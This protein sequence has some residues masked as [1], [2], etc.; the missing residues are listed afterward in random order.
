MEVGLI[1]RALWRHKTG[2]LLIALQMALTLAVLVNAAIMLQDHRRLMQRP[3]GLD[4]ANT[5]YLNSAVFQT[6]AASKAAV[7]RDL[8][9]LRQ[10]PGVQ[11]ATQINAIP[12]SGNGAWWSVATAAGAGQPEVSVAYYQVDEHGLAALGVQLIAGDNFS[13]SD[14]MWQSAEHNPQ[15]A[16]VIISAALARR[17]FGDEQSGVLGK[18]IYL[19]KTQPL[20]VIGVVAKLQA[21]WPDWKNAE[22]SL[23]V[24]VQQQAASHWYLVR[25][26]P[27]RRDALMPQLESR[28]AQ[29]DRQRIVSEMTTLPQTRQRAYQK[30]LAASQVL[31]WLIIALTG[32]T[33][34]GIAGLVMFSLQRRH[35]MIGIRRALGATRS[36]IMRFFM[37]E[38]LLISGLGALLG[39]AV[40]IGLNIWLVSRLQVSPLGP[41]LLLAGVVAMLLLGQLAVSYPA[42]LAT[43]LSPASICRGGVPGAAT[44]PISAL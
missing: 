13:A 42:W 41:D 11:A 34:L 43:R 38:N 14:V 9:L 4:E 37:L 1:L 32:L 20:I 31:W 24:P 21:A 23:L 7:Q 29:M 15:P 36:Q 39:S 10:T 26:E 33:G 16:K 5:F 27:G 25:S 30:E 22:L 28:L 8:A 12:L 3:S 6:N 35:R 40:A 17:L 18:T 2:A 44:R 19:D